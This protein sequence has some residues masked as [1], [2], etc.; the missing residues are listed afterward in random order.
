MDGAIWILFIDIV[1]QYR[2]IQTKGYIDKVA[3]VAVTILNCSILAM[4]SYSHLRKNLEII[5][6]AL[7]F[8]ILRE[9][10]F[11]WNNFS[12]DEGPNM[13]SKL[14]LKHISSTILLFF[15]VWFKC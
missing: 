11:F 8:A 2:S 12:E 3:M 6:W 10:I 13:Q 4:V 14:M 15:M 5:Q 7:S 1:K 9:Q